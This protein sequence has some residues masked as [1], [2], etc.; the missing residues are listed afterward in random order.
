[1]NVNQFNQMHQKIIGKNKSFE[2]YTRVMSSIDAKGGDYVK[3]ESQRL[4]KMMSNENVKSEQKDSFNLRLN[5]L[6]QFE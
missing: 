5:I 2:F 1:M 3:G 4:E 6:H